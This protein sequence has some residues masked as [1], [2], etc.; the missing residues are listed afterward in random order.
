M[1]SSPCLTAEHLTTIRQTTYWRQLFQALNLVRD[2]HKSSEGDWWSRSPFQP[3]ERTAS[4]HMNDRGWY[5]HSTGQGGGAIELVQRLH[6]GMTCYEAGRWLLDQG[7]CQLVANTR[8]EMEEVAPEVVAES[9]D[10]KANKPI[11]Q[12]LR[13][14]L[15]PSHPMFA[16]R[17]IPEDVLRDLGAG[18]L[19]RPAK[20]KQGLAKINRR[21]VFQIRGVEAQDG[22]ELRSILLGHIGRATTE[23]QAV[24]DGKWWTYPNF[25][26]SLELYNLDG[27]LLDPEAREQVE[28][29]G[30]VLLVEGCLDVAKLL[31]AGIRNVVASFGARLSPEQV[32]RL[33][34]AAEHLQV[35][36]VLVWFDRDQAGQAG[37][38][39]AAGA[40][41]SLGVLGARCF[42]W[43][44]AWQSPHRGRVGIPKE[45][46]DPCDFSI[47]QLRWLRQRGV[48]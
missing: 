6:G 19:D 26:K 35:R 7:I 48:L 15:D 24:Q 5:C 18:Y 9:E 33:C 3:E 34:F 12:D 39:A 37:A 14:Y 45:V 32:R 11:R 8:A 41:N 4:F 36:H 2:P 38:E 47:D 10:A 29:S 13:R 20:Q 1:K 25:Q 21:L 44:Q 22:G 28:A 46:A 43:E 40:I 17:G 23:E 30:H 16:V 27:L 42:D 31:A